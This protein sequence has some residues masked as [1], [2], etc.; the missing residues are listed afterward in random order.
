[1]SEEEYLYYS[2]STQYLGKSGI[3]EPCMMAM[4][5]ILTS[6][7]RPEKITAV[8]GSWWE[9]P[10]GYRSSEPV[11]FLVWDWFYPTMTIIPDGFGT[12][13]GEGGSGLSAVL[14]LIKF[15]GIPLLQTWVYDKQAFRELAEGTLTEAM[16]EALQEAQDYNWKFFPVS[17]VRKVKRGK[18][19]VLEVYRDNGHL[20]FDMQL[21]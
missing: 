1:M 19:Q 5:A 6:A 4:A 21:P 2:S 17:V 12:H 18:H 13:S 20:H 14:G 9:E 16:F 15:Y 10:D 3:T 11:L 8:I 7:F